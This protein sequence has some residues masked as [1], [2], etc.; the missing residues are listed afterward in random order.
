MF[1]SRKDA[2]KTQRRK[3]E[4]STLR[5]CVFFASLRETNFFNTEEL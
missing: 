2:K 4:I 5:L 3:E 1:V